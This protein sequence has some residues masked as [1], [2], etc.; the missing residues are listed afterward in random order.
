MLRMN[1]KKYEYYNTWDMHETK[2][3]ARKK[4]MVWNDYGVD[5]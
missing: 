1:R 5:Q 4:G 3:D 2:K